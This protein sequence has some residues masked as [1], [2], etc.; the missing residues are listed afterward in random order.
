MRSI[1]CVLIGFVLFYMSLNVKR[2]HWII[3]GSLI[4]MSFV[5]IG[6]ATV[7]MIIGI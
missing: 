2:E 7:F 4:V 3:K 5:M 1:N 6:I